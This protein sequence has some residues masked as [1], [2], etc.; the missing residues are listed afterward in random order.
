MPRFSHACEANNKTEEICISWMKPEGGNE[1]DDY[2]IE[3]K[4][5]HGSNHTHAIPYN[6]MESNIY[7]IKNLQP[8]QAVNVSIRASNSAGGGRI[9][10][11]FYATGK[12]FIII[13]NTLLLTLLFTTG[14]S[15]IKKQQNYWT[16][17]AAIYRCM[18]AFCGLPVLKMCLTVT[19]E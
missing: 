11:K 17:I 5:E 8:A 7:T 14:C 1:I 12:T 15:K 16:M 3:W 19:F 6:G 2:V 9:A 18:G 4:V 10:W 13:P